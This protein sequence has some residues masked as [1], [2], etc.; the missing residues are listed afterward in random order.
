[1]VMSWLSDGRDH[2]GRSGH[3][4]GHC[5]DT[6]LTF[7]G[8]Q[9]IQVAIERASQRSRPIQRSQC[10]LLE[11]RAY[12]GGMPRISTTDLFA[13]LIDESSW[14][15]WYQPD[16]QSGQGSDDSEL[17]R[18]TMPPVPREPGGMDRPPGSPGVDGSPE[19]GVPESIVTG[20]ARIS[21]HVICVVAS[22][23]DFLAGSV[24]REAAERIVEA[25][26]RAT[27][28]GLAVVGLPTSGGTRMQEGTPAFLLMAAIAAAVQRHRDAGLPYL[29]YLRHPTTGGVFATWGSL[30]DVTFAQ[31]G[32]LIGFLGPRVFESLY[33]EPFPDGVQTGEGLQQTGVVDGVADPLEWRSVVTRLLDAQEGKP[34]ASVPRQGVSP[35]QDP[36][37]G[38]DEGQV[39]SGSHLT[40]G[41]ESVERDGW[42]NIQRTRDSGRPGLRQ[43][44]ELADS[45]VPLSGTQEG[46]VAQATFFAVAEFGH[47]GCVVVGQDRS[48]QESGHLV[49][50]TDLRVA[51][52]AMRLAERWG[53]PLLTVV[54]TQGGELSPGAERGSLAGEIARCLAQMSAIKTPT[55]SVLLGGGGGGVALA[56]LPADRVLAVADSWVTPLPAEGASVIRY[57][58]VDRAAEMARAQS[59][60]AADLQEVGAVDRILPSVAGEDPDDRDQRMAAVVTAV[61]DELVRASER[62]VNLAVRTSRWQKIGPRLSS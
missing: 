18:Q 55:V 10:C 35:G 41:R 3:Q 52:R 27:S 31:P 49:G 2:V 1:M 62:D 38:S 56:M 53:L 28:L 34:T 57:R 42:V 39:S 17:M 50:P 16:D 8:A 5:A 48:A 14:E 33:G 43:F 4:T 12:A 19:S 32:S 22:D 51:R 46:E 26:D 29:V 15:S 30:G 21:G 60:T 58:T 54:D 23:F 6:S 13:D 24:G 47:V 11:S 40:L 61:A 59:I 25:F 20:S 9:W 44:M 45:V 36:P 7:D 37:E